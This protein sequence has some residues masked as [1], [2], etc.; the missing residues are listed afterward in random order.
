MARLVT[1]QVALWWPYRSLRIDY[2]LTWSDPEG[3]SQGGDIECRGVAG[4]AA[5][6][7]QV[8]EFSRISSSKISK[9]DSV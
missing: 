2:P 3:S 5:S 9:C 6:I 8:L 1:W 7:A 4:G